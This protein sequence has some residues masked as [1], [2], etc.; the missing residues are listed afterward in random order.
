[1]IRSESIGSYNIIFG[2]RISDGLQDL[3]AIARGFFVWSRCELARISV[4]MKK[5]CS[6]EADAE[7]LGKSNAKE[8]MK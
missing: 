5:P 4:Q 7:D 3:S 2:V 8:I 1:V 6:R